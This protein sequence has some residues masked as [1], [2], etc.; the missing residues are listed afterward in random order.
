MNIKNNIKIER[1]DDQARGICFIDNKIT[2]VP[3]TLIGEIVE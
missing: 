1:I 2:F 3:N